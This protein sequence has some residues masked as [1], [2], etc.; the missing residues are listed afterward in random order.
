MHA[1]AKLRGAGVKVVDFE[2]INHKEGFEIIKALY[3]P[4]GAGTQKDLLSQSGEPIAALTEF[5]FSV[6]RA[7]PLSIPENWA[8]NVRR[9]N[10]REE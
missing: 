7:E 6:S 2:P 3:F 9:D 5:A 10:Y 8:L 4:D 1:V